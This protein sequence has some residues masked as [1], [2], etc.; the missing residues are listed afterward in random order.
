MAGQSRPTQASGELAQ[1]ARQHRPHPLIGGDSIQ[2]KL[3]LRDHK[4]GFCHL[5]MFRFNICN[6][7]PLSLLKGGLGSKIS[8]SSIFVSGLNFLGQFR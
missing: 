4:G 5:G 7:E 2:Q 1:A 3:S 6:T 8:L